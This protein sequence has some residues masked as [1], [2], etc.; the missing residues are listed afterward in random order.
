M[1][2]NKG[3]KGRLVR[4]KIFAE[5]PQERWDELTRAAE[6]R[7]VAPH[8]IIFRQGDPGD[9]FYIVRSGRVRVFRQGSDGFERDLSVLGAG[10][11]FGQ[12]PLL[13]GE[14]AS[15]NTEALEETQLMVLS[16]EQFEG[17]LRDFPAISLAFM[18]QM[19]GW[20]MRANRAF[21]KEA[22]HQRRAPG[23]SW[24]HFV[25]II[26]VSV[27]LALLFNQS[28]PNGI[29]LFPKSPDRRAIPEIRA[30]Q[31]MEEVKKGDALI[32]DA[33]PE[34]FYQKK[35]IQGAINVPL[36]LF[37]ILYDV[38]FE[39]EEKA[40]KVIVYGGTFS[41]LY[42]W[43]LA[44]KLLQKGRK[45]VMVLKGGVETWEKAGYP[46]KEWEEKK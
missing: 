6:H 44:E 7:V 16:K 19:S 42:D 4:G 41:K 32:V 11:S 39:G 36:S 40:K 20:L 45:E 37:D 38:T 34:G 26:G 33:G 2:E 24:F 5:L 22:Q 46:V 30:A 13:T 9:R 28:N 18:K 15:V 31:A 17:I 25:L 43:E 12:L 29:P 27:L 3:K 35:H 21:E 1:N 14:T 8:T 23:L 10:A